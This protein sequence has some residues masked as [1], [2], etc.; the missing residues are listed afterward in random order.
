MFAVLLQNKAKLLCHVFLYIWL[1][2]NANKKK[3]E[4]KFPNKE[5]N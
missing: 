5:T 3:I 2:E 4:G 1:M